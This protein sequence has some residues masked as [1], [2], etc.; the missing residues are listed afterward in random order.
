F[1]DAQVAA[2]AAPGRAA[3]ARCLER[4]RRRRLALADAEILRRSDEDSDP[5]RLVRL[6]ELA[7][8]QPIDLD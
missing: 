1:I 3:V 7:A 2:K 4:E 6:V 5:D 8:R